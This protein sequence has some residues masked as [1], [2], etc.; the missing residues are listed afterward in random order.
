MCDVKAF[1]V[2][3]TGNPCIKIIGFVI[4]AGFLVAERNNVTFLT[5]N[6]WLSYRPTSLV[7]QK[8]KSALPSPPDLRKP[9]MVM[10]VRKVSFF[11][12]IVFVDD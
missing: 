5:T 4:L 12:K 1:D 9:R 10:I 7:L 2:A 8:V 3:F 6:S 11:Y